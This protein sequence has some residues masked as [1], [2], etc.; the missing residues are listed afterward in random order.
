M[1]MATSI[2]KPRP[3]AKF[4]K[5]YAGTWMLLAAFALAYMVTLAVQPSVLGEWTPGRTE[6][7]V[8]GENQAIARFAT[9][10]SGLKQTV[11]DI[12]RDVTVLRTTI[13]ASAARE[14]DLL[15]R[16]AT[17]EEHAKAPVATEAAAPAAPPAAPKTAAQRQAEARAKRTAEKTSAAAQAATQATAQAVD[18]GAVP[19]AA[20]PASVTVL[21]SPAPVAAPQAPAASP[22]ASPV[23]SPLATGSIAP[24]AHGVPAPPPPAAVATAPV[25][26]FGPG[27][28]K[29]SKPA[30]PAAVE[31][32]SGPS[33]DALRLNW[34]LL[35]DQ[36]GA[37]LKNLEPRYT[38]AGE[39]QPYQLVAG[40]IDTP[41]E[42]ARVC[43]QLKAKRVAC[44]VTGFGGNAL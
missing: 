42:A 19:A 40:P 18:S 17:I 8:S 32:S 26:A 13:Q 29:V 43:A 35:A 39:G 41:E 38:N 9:D 27:A 20:A 31:L 37:A 6:P 23:T 15:D 22:A 25:P 7:A 36:N 12:Q 21:N 1:T 3:A 28:I 30:H 11:G 10:L 5:I 2:P 34:S 44:R 16:I 4:A 33:L 14:K 24:P